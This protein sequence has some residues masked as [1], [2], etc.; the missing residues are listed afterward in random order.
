ML[1][2]CDILVLL[3][4]KLLQKITK[5]NVISFVGKIPVE[6]SEKERV[7]TLRFEL[8]RMVL[9]GEKKLMLFNT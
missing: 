1:H 7:E 2:N 3:C 4:I 6:T 5:G 8:K 9:V